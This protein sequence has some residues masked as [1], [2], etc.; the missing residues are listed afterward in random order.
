MR[1]FTTGQCT[2]DEGGRGIRNN[3]AAPAATGVAAERT[4]KVLM[5][6]GAHLAGS[7]K[8]KD[9]LSLKEKANYPP[10]PH[11]THPTPSQEKKKSSI[12]QRCVWP[13]KA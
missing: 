5:G 8:S 2:E 6:A 10:H 13:C 11:P 3:T 1:S 12:E 9:G 4:L 7:H